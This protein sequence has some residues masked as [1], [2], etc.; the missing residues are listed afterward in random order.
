MTLNKA[1]VIITPKLGGNNLPEK[2]NLIKQINRLIVGKVIEISIVIILVGLSIPAWSVFAAKIGD[3][4]VI[5]IED[6]KLNFKEKKDN[7]TDFLT[8]ENNYAINKNYKIY[9]DVDKNTDFSTEIVINNKGY[10]LNDFYYKEKENNI[11]FTLIDK[12]IVAAIDAYNI[13]LKIAKEGNEYHYIFEEINN[14]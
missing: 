13:Q 2:E 6:C 1:S 12:D 9:L 5:N 8:I 10:T 14:F 7:A 11:R 3:I 4:N